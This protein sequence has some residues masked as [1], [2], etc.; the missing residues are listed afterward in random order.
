MSKEFPRRCLENSHHSD[1]LD[2]RRCFRDFER[3][4]LRNIGAELWAELGEVVGKERGLVAGA[5]DG[6]V[7]EAGV[8]QVRVD[9]GVG[10][11]EDALGGETLGT[12]AGDGVAM[13]EMT[14]LCGV[15]FDLA[16]AVETGGN[17]AVGRN[18]FDD[19]KV[20]IGN[21]E[22]LVGRGELDTVAGG[23][24]TVDLPV[25]ADAGQTAWVVGD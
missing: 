24:L 13:I 20:A 21:T 5:G 15:E 8:E 7:A 22:R 17:E 14:V 10:V 23:K 18:G 12:V 16:V 4:S 11:D 6:D 19:C 25:D 9:A 2:N 1:S 3:G